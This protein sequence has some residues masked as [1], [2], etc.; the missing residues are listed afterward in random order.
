MRSGRRLERLVAVF[1]AAVLITP[2]IWRSNDS[3]KERG[4]NERRTED[5]S[6]RRD[7]FA[8]LPLR[9]PARVGMFYR[10]GGVTGSPPA[11]VQVGIS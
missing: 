9:V 5:S 7:C 10:A 8:Q 2:K 1:V 3:A 6:A 11:N 4:E